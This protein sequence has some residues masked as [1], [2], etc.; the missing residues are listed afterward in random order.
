MVT[1]DG[2]HQTALRKQLKSKR[3]LHTDM[4][5]SQ[6][7]FSHRPSLSPSLKVFDWGRHLVEQ[8]LGVLSKMID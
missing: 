6:C 7:A 3:H 1:V 5:P 8:T 4:E 2:G